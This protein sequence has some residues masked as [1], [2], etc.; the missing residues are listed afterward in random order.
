MSA[1]KGCT[2]YW[3]GADDWIPGDLDQPWTFLTRWVWMST[4]KVVDHRYRWPLVELDDARDGEEIQRFGMEH[5]PR[6]EGDA[7]QGRTRMWFGVRD[8]QSRLI[9]CG[10]VHSTNAGLGNL[11]GLV[12]HEQMRGQ[13]IGTDLLVA[14]TRWSI[15]MDKISTLS[16]FAD[17]ERAIKLY[18]SMG[19]RLEHRFRFWELIP[20]RG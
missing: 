6:F 13:Q 19:Y 3:V 1:R 5:N 20:R 4:T 7:G 14:L 15:E 16:A 18:E 9:G 10:G 11:G 17:N 8:E 12:V 2:V